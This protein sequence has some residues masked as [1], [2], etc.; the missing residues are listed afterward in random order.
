MNKNTL[1]QFAEQIAERKAQI[2]AEFAPKLRNHLVQL[3]RK[4]HA[5]DP[6][7]T[8]LIAAMG[9]AVPT[10][11]FLNKGDPSS[12]FA[13]DRE[14]RLHDA[15]DWLAEQCDEYHPLHPETLAFF[16]E[17]AA[18]DDRLCA[19]RA[20]DLPYVDDITPADLTPERVKRSRVWKRTHP[21]A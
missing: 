5:V 13:E 2:D 14:P 15:G 17:V 10:G 11:Q 3:F 16:E 1:D 7:L 9:R 21:R 4:A 12:E 6:K 19:Q 8:G 18:Y 20:D